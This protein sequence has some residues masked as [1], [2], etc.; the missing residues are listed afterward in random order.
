MAV[1]VVHGRD[2]KGEAFRRRFEAP[3]ETDLTMFLATRSLHASS[4]RP[5]PF[6]SWPFSR[7]P[8]M[9]MIFPL[10]AWGV[11]SFGGAV[12]SGGLTWMRERDNQHV[13]E[14][15][16]REGVPAEGR[17]TALREQPQRKR[18]PLQVIEYQY[19]A[20]DGWVH[21]GELVGKPGHARKGR[22]DLSLL[23]ATEVA[24]G[25]R[26]DVVVHPQ[27]PLLHAPFSLDEQFLARHRALLEARVQALLLSLLGFVSCGWLVW[28]A[29]LR[30]GSHFEHASDPRIVEISSGRSVLDDKTHEEPAEP[31]RAS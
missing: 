25:D 3:S 15:L 1:Y 12:A 7:I 24:E 31:V 19:R 2:H 23:P 20:G 17:V 29:S 16:A 18:K 4:I 14:T 21:R 5:L 26:L 11:I 6:S 30:L 9:T 22:H 10:F 13:Y 8:F 27:T 28:N